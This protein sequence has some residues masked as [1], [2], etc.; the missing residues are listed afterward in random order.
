[1]GFLAVA[2]PG[3]NSFVCTSC[4]QTVVPDANAYR[5]WRHATERKDKI[6]CSKRDLHARYA[7]MG[8]PREQW[9]A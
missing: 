1:M 7:A 8:L 5:G 3:P 9:P 6:S 2:W 4:A